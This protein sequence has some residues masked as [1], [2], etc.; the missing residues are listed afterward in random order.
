[1]AHGPI[2]FCMQN[3]NSAEWISWMTLQGIEVRQEM[4]KTSTETVLIG[5]KKDEFRK[6]LGTD[7][8]RAVV[9]WRTSG[10]DFVSGLRKWVHV[11][12]ETK[13]QVFSIVVPK[14]ASAVP[15]IPFYQYHIN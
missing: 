10:N 1:M 9:D 11:S 8:G 13:M 15:C 4:R 2:L 3:R 12:A 14:L 6:H 7:T 5:E